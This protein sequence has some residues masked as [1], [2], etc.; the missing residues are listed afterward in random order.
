M[1]SSLRIII[2]I[3]VVLELTA[4]GIYFYS[5]QTKSKKTAPLPNL[6]VV[7]AFQLTNEDS[8]QFSN[9]NLL[10]KVTVADFI[11]TSCGGPCPMMSSK[12]AS[13]QAEFADVPAIHLLSFSVDP[14]Y[15][16][17]S[18]LKEYGQKFGA[19]Q[20]RWTFLTGDKHAIYQLARYG[21]YLTTED[22][23]NAIIHS[24]KFILIDTKGSIRGYYDYDDSTAVPKLVNDARSLAT[25]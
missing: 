9:Q 15:D 22:E 7:P 3:T 23:E 21:F 13:L 16:T 25:E 1:K 19:E 4:V 8:A 20:G 18:I 14:E 6:G 5:S 24:T 12:M 11:F 17:P 10:G 2:I